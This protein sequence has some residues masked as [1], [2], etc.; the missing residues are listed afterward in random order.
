VASARS[1]THPFNRQ[2]II[3][4]D[5]RL[6]FQ[7]GKAPVSPEEMLEVI[8]FMEAADLSK[9]RQG[10]AARLDEVH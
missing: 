4:V 7:T 10:A 8:A 9:Q 6:F 5:K 2:S 3:G 1:C